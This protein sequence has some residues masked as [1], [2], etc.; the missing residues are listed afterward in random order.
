[1]NGHP[2]RLC[3]V[4]RVHHSGLG[5]GADPGAHCR[6]VGWW[7]KTKPNE[8]TDAATIG[9]TSRGALFAKVTNSFIN[10]GTLSG[11]GGTYVTPGAPQYL[12]VSTGVLQRE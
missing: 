11:G 8:A 2:P 1:M 4:H 10:S 5:Y 7:I 3:A 9:S 6:R 12:K